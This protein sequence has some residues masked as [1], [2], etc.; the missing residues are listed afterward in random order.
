M[1]RRTFFACA[2]AL[3]A[4][5]LAAVAPV[6]RC[7]ETDAAEADNEAFEYPDPDP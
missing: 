1:D 3:L 6:V 4:L 2:A 7:Q 5:S